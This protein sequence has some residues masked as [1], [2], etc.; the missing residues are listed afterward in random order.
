M[1][2][3]IIEEIARVLKV[4]TGDVDISLTFAHLGGHSLAT[5][6]LARACKQR[7]IYISVGEILQCSSVT[8]LISCARSIQ[9]SSHIGKAEG[10]V[11]TMEVINNFLNYP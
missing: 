8:D 2:E 5:L 7:G 1:Q 10:A 4:S 11:N 9:A 3:Q 6:K